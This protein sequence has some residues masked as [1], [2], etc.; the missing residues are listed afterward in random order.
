MSGPVRLNN[1]LFSMLDRIGA[2]TD[3]LKDS[4]GRPTKLDG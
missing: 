2:P 1:L 4:T 3:S